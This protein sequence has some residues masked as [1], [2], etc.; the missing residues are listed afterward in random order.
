MLRGRSSQYLDWVVA[1]HGWKSWKVSEINHENRANTK[2]LTFVLDDMSYSW[3]GKLFETAD[4][5][6]TSKKRAFREKLL[7]KCY[8][9]H[10][11][12][13]IKRNTRRAI[14]MMLL[15]TNHHNN[16]KTTHNQCK[17]KNTSSFHFWNYAAFVLMSLSL[18]YG[19]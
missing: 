14:L 10:S 18:P 3:S 17:S 5:L 12:A 6:W 4:S 11:S 1:L 19:L 15:F 2:E 9:Y 16:Q 7:L 8:Y 13:I